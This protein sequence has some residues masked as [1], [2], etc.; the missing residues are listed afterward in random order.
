MSSIMLTLKLVM[1]NC[2]DKQHVRIPATVFT[3]AS[4]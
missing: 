1:L 4:Q 3:L 2:F